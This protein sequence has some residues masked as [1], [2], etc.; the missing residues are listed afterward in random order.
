MSFQFHLYNNRV[1]SA[2]W[3]YTALQT[4]RSYTLPTFFVEAYLDIYCLVTLLM[5]LRPEDASLT[6]RAFLQ[7]SAIALE[8]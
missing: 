3:L 7:K 6:I 2:L 4:L 5:H 8:V 1:I